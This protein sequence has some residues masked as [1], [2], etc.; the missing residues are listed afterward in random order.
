MRD[1]DILYVSSAPVS[2][3]QRFVSI[4]SSMAFTF[5]GLGEAIPRVAQ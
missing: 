5:I 2:D 3:L 4:L 1:E